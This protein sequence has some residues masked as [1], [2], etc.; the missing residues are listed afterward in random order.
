MVILVLSKVVFLG[1]NNKPLLGT[2]QLTC[3]YPDV[4]VALFDSSKLPIDEQ[5]PTWT[6]QGNRE[7]EKICHI[8]PSYRVAFSH[9]QPFRSREVNSTV[10]IN[11]LPGD[12]AGHWA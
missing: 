5:Y 2:F 7:E 4:N 12:V 11:I 3:R 1:F 9:L 10:N 6:K 8:D